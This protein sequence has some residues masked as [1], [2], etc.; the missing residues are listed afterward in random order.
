[1]TDNS[2]SFDAIEMVIYGTNR[3][4]V[5]TP[6]PE[7]GSFSLPE[8]EGLDKVLEDTF[9]SGYPAIILDLGNVNYMRIGGWGYLINYAKR[10]REE[11]KDFAIVGLNDAVN[12]S[13]EFFE[14]DR[15]IPAYDTADKAVSHL[16]RKYAKR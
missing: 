6:T 16:K 13:F 1:M 3:A 8:L 10:G 4:A 9:D 12:S 2:L 11:G 14:L 5:I 7:Q 15:A